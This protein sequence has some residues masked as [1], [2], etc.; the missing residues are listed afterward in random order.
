MKKSFLLSCV[1]LWAILRRANMQ[2]SLPATVINCC[3]GDILL[4]LDSSGSIANYEFSRLL[5]FTAELLH[6]FTLGRGHVRVGLLQVGTQ[7]NLE[8]SLD[9]HSTQESLQKALRRVN[10]LQGD[11][12]TE[13]ALRVAQQLLSKM[14]NNVP[15]IL[16]WLTDG[17][18]PGDVDELMTEL[19]AQGVYVLAVSTVHGNY[20]VLQR[21]ITSPL[22]SHLYSVD[23]DNIE[24]ITEDLR[25]AIIEIIRAERLRVVHLTSSSAVLQWRPVLSTGD[26]YYELYYISELISDSETRHILPG[27]SSWAEIINLQPDT[28]Y[29]AFLRPES[30]QRLFTTLSVS[31][32]TLPDVLSPVVVSLS[33]SG[34]HQIR[35]SWGPLQPARVLRYVVE[36]GTIPSGPI[37][38]LV[39]N[40]QQN[41]T[42]LTGLDPGTQYLVTVSALH[43]NGKERAMSVKAC[44]QEETALQ[45]LVDLQ[46]TSVDLQE[47]N[48]AWQAHQDGLKGYWLSWERDSLH[49]FY[50][51]PSISSVYLPPT[52]RGTQLTHLAPSSRVCVSPV[53]SSGQGDGIC[54]T[55]ETHIGWLS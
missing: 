29:K 37:Q 35:V 32:H 27:D 18:Q 46:L 14:E 5:Q 28:S 20:Q 6:P 50:W 41:S 11:T 34:P 38:T 55:A 31:F 53:Y 9:V 49:S 2:V 22:E 51:K 4:L 30:N 45:A 36:Y 54:C 10:Q 25:E 40:S 52:S 26:G 16:L 8:F 19:K 33:D 15:K 17:V 43:V 1:L 12:N 47:V 21:A 23:I 42:L 13:A 7:P 39:L 3:E 48:V 24:I 44:T